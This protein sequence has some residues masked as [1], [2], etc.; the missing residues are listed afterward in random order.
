[1]KT[2]I[3]RIHCITAVKK[4]ENRAIKT[5]NIRLTMNQVKLHIVD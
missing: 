3:I 4:S 2:V 1:M 5:Y